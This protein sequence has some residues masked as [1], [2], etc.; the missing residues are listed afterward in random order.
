[1]GDGKWG[2]SYTDKNGDLAGSY[3]IDSDGNVTK[4]DE[5]GVEI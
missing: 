2:F 5:H 4:Y 3:I 1:M